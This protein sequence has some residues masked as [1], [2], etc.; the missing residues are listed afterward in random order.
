MTKYK[1]GFYTRNKKGAYIAS[2]TCGTVKLIAFNEYRGYGDIAVVCEGCGNKDFVNLVSKSR[3]VTPYIEILNKDRKGFKAKRTNL[4]VFYDDDYNVMLKS[5]MVQVLIY[6]LVNSYVRLYKNGESVGTRWGVLEENIGR[7]FVSVNDTDFIRMISTGETESLYDFAW[8]NLSRN[9]R[10]YYGGD[11]RI[12]RGLLKILRGYTYMQVLSNAGFPN[13][14]RF[15]ERSGY[16]KPTINANGTNPKDIFGLPKFILSYI[17]ENENIGIFEIK[18]IKQALEKVDGNRFREIMEIVKDESTIRDLCQTLDNLVEI[19]D[20]YNYNNLKKLTLYLFREI[21][22]NQGIGNPSNGATL[23]KDYIK[24]STRLGQEFEKYPRSLKKEHDITQM[25]YKVQ[26]SEMKKKEFAEAIESEEYKSFE[27]KKKD[28]TIITPKEMSDLI[29]EGSELSHC[30]ASYVDSIVS[31]RCKIF[32]LRNVEDIDKPLATIEVRGENV[33][34]ARGY[35]NRS[36]KQSERDFVE[37][38]AKKKK[39]ELNYYY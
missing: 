11:R 39:L 30:V 27:Y 8:S 21:R 7:F 12:Y 19:H 24:M 36:L 6:D 16:N 25:N 4:S 1:I 35:A 23:L 2:C 38:W 18:Q 28:F 15:Y 31:K 5:N 20:K 32:F 17:R 22:M 10:N 14:S 26:E 33:R 29:K 9:D 3:A 13:I 34:Q 37:E